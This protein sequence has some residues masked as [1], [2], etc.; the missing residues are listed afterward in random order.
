[1]GK[2]SV[3]SQAPKVK[4]LTAAEKRLKEEQAKHRSLLGNFYAQ[5]G[6]PDKVTGKRAG[7]PGASASGGMEFRVNNAPAPIDMNALFTTTFCERRMWQMAAEHDPAKNVEEGPAPQEEAPAAEIEEIIEGEGDEKT[8]KEPEE[9]PPMSTPSNSSAASVEKG[10]DGPQPVRPLRSGFSPI[11]KKLQQ[12]KATQDAQ[13][14]P[15]ALPSRSRSHSNAGSQVSSPSKSL[16]PSK[17]PTSKVQL[18]LG[19][20]A[21][22]R[23][24]GVRARAESS[25]QSMFGSAETAAKLLSPHKAVS[26]TAVR[27]RYLEL[28]GDARGSDNE[29]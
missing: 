29:D 10:Q 7:S 8:E 1:M 20:G 2:S 21:A 14:K 9:A 15:R 16:S 23:A 19:G 13:K 26:A 25:M 3:R 12:A 6:S 24:T 28:L 27:S 22:R 11:K 18:G 5:H 17:K 4:P